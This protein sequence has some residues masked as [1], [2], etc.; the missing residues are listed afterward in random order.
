MSMAAAASAARS[1]MPGPRVRSSSRSEQPA[2]TLR[3]AAGDC[4]VAWEATSASVLSRGG[5]N[6]V[7]ILYQ[8][9]R[10]TGACR[11]GVVRF[12]ELS[13]CISCHTEDA[14]CD[15][16]RLDWLLIRIE[17]C[18]MHSSSTMVINPVGIMSFH[19]GLCGR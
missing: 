18:I 10:L 12:F 2:A 8:F 15:T 17:G 6:H 7:G 9:L 4:G 3:S 19:I 1:A 11:R 5:A 16:S 13:I 14:R